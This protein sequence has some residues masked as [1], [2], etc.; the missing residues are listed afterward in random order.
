MNWTNLLRSEV[1]Q[2]YH[3][4]SRLMDLVDGDLD[5]KPSSGDNWMTMGQLLLH[6]TGA[7]GA[8]FRGFVTGDWG[9]PD[10]VDMENM[11]EE[12]MLP[13]AEALP[14]AGSVDEARQALAADKELAMSMIAE[15]EARMD[16][17]TP[18]PW[19]P[20]HPAP[21]GQQ[22]L[23]MVNHLAL[24]KAQLFYYLK[25]QGKPVNTMNLFGMV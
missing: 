4:A 15:A 7:C 9:M 3:A 5:W 19:A 14:S 20:D 1:E 2:A 8:T 17:P 10:G 23:G 6:M 11:P 24:H 21:L 12:A 22:M 25:M 13:P 18:A 16:D